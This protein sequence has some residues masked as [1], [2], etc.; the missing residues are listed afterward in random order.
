MLVQEQ[1]PYSHLKLRRE[2]MNLQNR[3][4]YVLL[5]VVVN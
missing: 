4:R 5:E 2:D 3:D 1:H